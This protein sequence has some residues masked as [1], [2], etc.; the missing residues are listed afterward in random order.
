MRVLYIFLIFA[1]F[2]CCKH[3]IM[4]TTRYKAKHIGKKDLNNYIKNCK[5]VYPPDQLLHKRIYK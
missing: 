2:S 1:L 5:G 4:Y 3:T